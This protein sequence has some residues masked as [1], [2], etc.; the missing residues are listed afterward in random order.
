MRIGKI[1]EIETVSYVPDDALSIQE[2]AIG[3]TLR[4]PVGVL[5]YRD[6]INSHIL[7]IDQRYLLATDVGTIESVN[8]AVYLDGRLFSFS[9]DAVY[10]YM[11]YHIADDEMMGKIR[12]NY[13]NF[14]L[15]SPYGALS[16]E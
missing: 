6:I 10:T 9:F 15:Q 13:L 16:Y 1:Y 11:L 7:S 2:H 8:G 14:R 4:S 5:S 3:Y 12:S